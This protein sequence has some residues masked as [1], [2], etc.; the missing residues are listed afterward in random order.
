[1]LVRD[2]MTR[3]LITIESSSPL[4]EAQRL[5]LRHRIRQLP[6]VRNGQLVGIITHRDLR[7]ARSLT[8]SV[9]SRMTGKPFTIAPDAAIDEAAQLLRT[10]RIGGLPVVD[11][12]QLLGIITVADV[13]DG[14]VA[15]SG[16]SEPTYRLIVSGR[17]RDLER[18]VRRTAE[19]LG[20]EIKWLHRHSTARPSQLQL[21]AK[22][23][24]IDD[25][26]TA[27]QANGDT[28]LRVVAAQRRR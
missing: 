24:R 9:A 8:Q 5:L 10:Y 13:L 11:Q 28:V 2:R 26:V 7:S 27:L 18:R 12:K 15:L 22:V 20:A 1:M 19:R 21:R 3:R 6:V 25:L 14:L 4:R 16:V 17:K 23:K